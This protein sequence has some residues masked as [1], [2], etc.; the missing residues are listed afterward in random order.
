MDA[1]VS[2][3]FKYPSRV[4]ARG[5]V[6]W[7]PVVPVWLVIM[8]AVVALVIAAVAYARVRGVPRLERGTMF[9][10]RTLAL[11]IVVACLLR[12]TL[13]V[14]SAVP[15]RNM[16]AILL[17]DSRSM[18]VSDVGDSTRAAAVARVFD[19]SSALVRALADR[20]ALRF[21]RFAADVRPTGDASDLSATGTRTDLAAALDGARDELAGTPLAGMIVVTDGADNGGQDI[22]PAILAL[23]ARRVP[24][25]TVGVGLERFP[26]DVA[27]E[28]VALPARPLV[29]ATLLV[30]VTLRLRG[31]GG[32]KLVLTAESDGRLVGTDTITLPDREEIALTRLRLAELQP[33]SHRITVRASELDGET[34]SENNVS[35]GLVQVRPGP[36]RILY[37]EG[38]P[39]P[40]LGFIR[41]AVSTDS[42]VQL[43]TLL[44]SAENKFL[45]LGVRDSMELAAGF[46]TSR[47]E[48]FAYRGIILGSIEASFF[49]PDQLRML[50]EFVSQRG[51]GLLALGGRGTL[52]EGGYRGT[53]VAEVLPIALDRSPL[54]PDAAATELFIQPTT[55]G[56]AQASLQI[57]ATTA[58]SAQRWDSLPP[59]TVVNALGSL[60]PGA[61]A[62]LTGRREGESD[63]QPVFATQRFGRGTASVF[64]VQDS[65]LWKMHADISVDDHTHETLWRQLAR[66]LT[67]DASERVEI[68]AV[69]SRVAPGEPV[70]L[71]ARV[72]DE[73]FLDI[74]DASV[75]ASVTAPSGRVSDVPLEW[76]LAEDGVY[77]GRFIAEEAGLYR[78]AAEAR[79]GV[80]TTHAA[81]A[82]LLADD[83]GADVEQA[84]L[85]A[86]LLRRVADQTGGRYY[87]LDEAAQLAE[88]VNYTESGVTVREAHDLWDMPAVFL[89]IALLL[90]GEWALRRS[91][92]LA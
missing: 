80:D 33:G 78:L 11:L 25:Y 45:R 85:R 54:E 13:V 37:M 2:F 26:R 64:A 69:P 5:D 58:A 29:G 22:A 84:E 12:P 3:L 30:D 36:D 77:E 35:H 17:D 38:E 90:A 82:A 7:S 47:K 92:G 40:E 83:Q 18:Q 21:Y 44:R 32:E 48:L 52:A 43:V 50:A 79:R 81:P 56:R 24:V 14:A 86:P 20:F 31:V 42:A 60:R 41:R 1:V 46:P 73:Q 67:E 72:A 91:R 87:A 61:T 8:L 63:D 89:T 55:A 16:L 49:R 28:R 39:R 27:I 75:T 62:L 23:R 4:W 66:S 51:G 68:A 10:L 88:D 65:W 19:D 70:M 71:R 57:A 9:A 74:N 34:V 15:Q 6:V 53:P 76:T 59:L